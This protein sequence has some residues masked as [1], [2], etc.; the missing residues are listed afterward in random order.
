MN[1]TDTRNLIASV[2]LALLGV[3]GLFALLEGSENVIM[4]LGVAVALATYGTIEL[5]GAVRHLPTRLPRDAVELY[6]SIKSES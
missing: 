2:I 4:G 3:V 1:N 5:H 6:R